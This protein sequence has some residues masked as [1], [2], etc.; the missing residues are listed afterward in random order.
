MLMN[1][2]MPTL[3]GIFIFISRKKSCSTE[4]SPEKDF[5]TSGPGP[6]YKTDLNL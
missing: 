6:R 3:T 1:M 5:I 4:L 2:K